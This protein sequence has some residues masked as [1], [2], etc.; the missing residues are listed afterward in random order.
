M[1]DQATLKSQLDYDPLTG[2]FTWRVSRPGVK[3]G[4][5][6]GCKKGDGYVVITVARK[7]YLA[8]RLAWLFVFGFLPDEGMIDHEDGDPSNNAI[9]NLRPATG[10]QNQMNRRVSKASTTG[11]KGVSYSASRK[12]YQAI[13]SANGKRKM[14]GYFSTVDLAARAYEAAA[15]QLHGEFARPSS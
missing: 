1:I 14:L 5:R 6:A 11:V 12:K 4:S 7:Q 10:F 3:A 13:I 2:I 9:R 8:H 15:D